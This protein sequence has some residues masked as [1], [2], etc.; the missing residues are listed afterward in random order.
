MSTQKKNTYIGIRDTAKLA[1]VSTA[2]VS[3]VI[4]SPNMT[5]DAVREKVQKIIEEYNYIPNQPVQK[6]FSKTSNT[7]AV[8]IYDMENP[9][10]I[11]LIKELNQICLNHNYILLI[12]NTE[13][14]PDLEKKYLHFCLANRCAGII[15]TEGI[16]SD[17]FESCKIPIPIAFLD[18]KTH[19]KFSSVRSNNRQIMQSVV[20]YLYNLGHRKIAFVGCKTPMD[21]V[22]SRQ[23][24]YI[25]FTANKNLPLNPEY[26]YTQ[27]TQ[28]TLQAGGQAL[29]YFLSLSSAPT[30]IICCNDMIALGTLNAAYSL[31]LKVPD[32]ISVVGFDNVISNI[33]QPQI[34]TVE[35]DLHTI[36]NELFQ[37][38][39]SPPDEPVSKI[40]NATFIQGASCS[41]I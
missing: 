38:I 32:D 28:L 23:K 12:C 27:N 30:A 25:E 34:T 35:Q 41:R 10:F 4:N 29:Q 17:I 39:I 9:F 15:L 24:G 7:I 21:S 16:D 26:I 13:S 6:L 40:I 2:T 18:R 1:G 31:G 22:L 33:H 11:K 36:S 3:R 37:L 5:S 19:G 14:N 8:F 20:D